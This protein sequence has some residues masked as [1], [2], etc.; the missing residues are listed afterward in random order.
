MST[1]PL[2]FVPFPQ[3]F[4]KEPEP[5][6]DVDIKFKILLTGVLT[7]YTHHKRYTHSNLTREQ[8]Q[9]FAEVREMTK[10]GAIRLSVSDKGG[11]FVVMP[12]VLD[13]KITEAHLQDTTLYCPVTESDFHNQCR[14]LN[15][16]WMSIG[17]SSGL[18]EKFLS[19]L[20]I[21]TPTCPVFYS[22]IKTHKLTPDDLHSMTVDTY[23]IRP[24]ISCV[25]GPADRISWFLNKIVSQILPK[26]PS[27]LPNTKHFLTQLHNARF[28]DNCAIESFDVAS[29]YTNVQNSEALQALSEMLN[30]HGAHMETYGLSRTRLL[31][32]I[33]ECLSYNIFRCSGMYFAQVRG[34]AMGQRLAPVLA[35]AS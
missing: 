25:G 1:R 30:I 26:I 12:Q 35:T 24:I 31:T 19:R 29:L 4:Y 16:I 22:L 2:P 21:D 11:E 14:R 34:L 18:D 27:H 9:G 6:R 33:K 13:R 32:L 28:D 17:K 7:A 23:K 3:S 8:W 20:K 10:N 15:D 5:V